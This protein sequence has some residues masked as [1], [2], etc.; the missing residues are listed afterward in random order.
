MKELEI[1][2][3]EDNPG[4]VVL[5]REALAGYPIPVQLVVAHDGEEALAMLNAPDFKPNL[6]ILDLNMARVDGHTVL[7]RNRQKDVPAVIFSSTQNRAEVQRALSLG[8]REFVKKPL[9][10]QSYAEAVRGILDRWLKTSRPT[11]AI[12]PA[13]L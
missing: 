9:S 10:F 1:F 7:E 4:D 6:I 11:S 3:V 13:V 8:A 2:L 5:T 12:V